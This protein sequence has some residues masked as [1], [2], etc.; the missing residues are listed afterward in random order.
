M[1]DGMKC[2]MVVW[3][4]GVVWWCGMRDEKGPNG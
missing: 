3:Y 1:Q 2:G 4:G